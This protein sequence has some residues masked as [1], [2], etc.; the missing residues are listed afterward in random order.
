MMRAC[1]QCGE[2]TERYGRCEDCTASA[3]AQAPGRHPSKSSTRRGYGTAWRKLS[4]RARRMQPWCSHCGSHDDLT[5]DHTPQAWERH[6]AGKPIRLQ[7]IDVLCRSCNSEKG[8]ARPQSKPSK[9]H[10]GTRGDG[11]TSGGPTRWGEAKFRSQMGTVADKALSDLSCDLRVVAKL[12]DDVLVVVD[13]PSLICVHVPYELVD[14]SIV[15]LRRACDLPD[16]VGPRQKSGSTHVDPS[17]RNVGP[18]DDV[19]LLDVLGSNLLGRFH[20]R[21]IA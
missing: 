1:A 20:P 12:D 21:S 14:R 3:V 6:E 8:R 9:P 17:P 16:N 5:A 18:R 4:E 15:G 10:T 19:A 7:D 11:V 2:P 13:D